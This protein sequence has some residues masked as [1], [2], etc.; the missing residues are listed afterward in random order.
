MLIEKNQKQQHAKYTISNELEISRDQFPKLKLQ[1][2]NKVHRFNSI[3]CSSL[4]RGKAYFQRFIDPLQ[5]VYLEQERQNRK[6]NRSQYIRQERHE[7]GERRAGLSTEQLQKK[8]KQING[9]SNGRPLRSSLWLDNEN[10]AESGSC[11]VPGTELHQERVLNYI[12][13]L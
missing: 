13:Q 1:L 4:S 12:G 11:V 10:E 2:E 6:Q 7:S 9:R 8:L 3:S 5:G